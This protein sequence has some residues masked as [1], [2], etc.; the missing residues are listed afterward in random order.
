MREKKKI[1]EEIQQNDKL[2]TTIAQCTPYKEV[3][4]RWRVSNYSVPPT[5]E[6][7]TGRCSR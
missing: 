1:A 7:V 6:M 5:Y 2:Q 3:V 4:R